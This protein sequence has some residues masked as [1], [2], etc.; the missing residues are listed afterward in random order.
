MATYATLDDV[1][2]RIPQVVLS[3]TSKPTR[4]T[5]QKFLDAVHGELEGV[6][7]NM[8]YQV[9]VVKADSPYGF[10]QVQTAEC[11]AVGSRI[12]YARA[13]GVG[14]DGAVTSA[15]RMQKQY[16]DMICAWNTRNNPK[17]L[18]DVPRNGDQVQK[19][20]HVLDGVADSFGSSDACPRVTMD[21]VF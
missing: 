4:S 15:E 2:D 3:D 7:K 11:L 18:T 5:A 14:G 17:E 20:Q 8:G 13:N 16:E 1:L 9:P 21:Q 10:S 6:L 19:P 12:L